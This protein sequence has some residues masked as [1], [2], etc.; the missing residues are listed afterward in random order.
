ML[1]KQSVHGF[2]LALG[3]AADCSAWTRHQ[4]MTR[5]MMLQIPE[6]A[7]TMLTSCY[8]LTLV[9]LKQYLQMEAADEPP[10]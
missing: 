4:Y 9:R 5:Q 2:A 7:G 3:I 6:V 10:A 1:A 8:Q